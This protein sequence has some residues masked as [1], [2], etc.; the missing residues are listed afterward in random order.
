MSEGQ[1]LGTGPSKIHMGLTLAYSPNFKFKLGKQPI[2]WGRMTPHQQVAEFTTVLRS[3]YFPLVDEI[4]Y[5]FELTQSGQMHC[6]A[7]LE[8][9]ESNDMREYYLQLIRKSVQQNAYIIK[10]CKGNGRHIVTSNY[11]HLVDR[12]KWLDYIKKDL[13][14]TP[15]GLGIMSQIS[16]G[17]LE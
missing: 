11:I 7:L 13:K 6:H 16:E 3:I 4:T 10:M 8:L 15:Y 17:A 5:S 14:K 1:T 12:D 9:T 2:V